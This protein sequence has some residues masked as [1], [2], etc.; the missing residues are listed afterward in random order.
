[1]DIGGDSRVSAAPVAESGVAE[2]VVGPDSCGILS[3]I[4]RRREEKAEARGAVASSFSS[5]ST[6][7]DQKKSFVSMIT[8][9][10]FYPGVATLI[11]VQ[12]LESVWS[13]LCQL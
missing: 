1:M 4:P 5:S 3:S 8:N 9:D 10:S 11:K 7:R 13:A 2:D 6:G 12:L